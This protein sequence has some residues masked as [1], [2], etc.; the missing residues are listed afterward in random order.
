MNLNFF[1]GICFLII[2][3][4]C[5]QEQKIK[6]SIP[7]IPD[8]R[9]ELTI[10]NWYI[11]HETPEK[12]GLT[13]QNMF[14]NKKTTSFT[15]PEGI[16]TGEEIFIELQ[17]PVFVNYLK[18]HQLPLKNAVTIKKIELFVDNA[19]IGNYHLTDSVPLNRLINS[20]TIRISE[21]SH[22]KIIDNICDT[23]YDWYSLHFFDKKYFFAINE[24]DFYDKNGLKFHKKMP[25]SIELKNTGTTKSFFIPKQQLVYFQK[26]TPLS[27]TFKQ[28]VIINQISLAPANKTQSKIKKIRISINNQHFDVQLKK[29]SEMQNIKFKQDINTE[30]LSIQVLDMYENTNK[31]ATVFYQIKLSNNST[32][33]KIEYPRIENLPD[34]FNKIFLFECRQKT[35]TSYIFSKQLS[36]KNDRTFTIIENHRMEKKDKIIKYE[37]IWNFNKNKITLKYWDTEMFKLRESFFERKN[38]QLVSNIF[39]PFYLDL[40]PSAFVNIEQLSNDFILDMKYATTDNFTK[41]QLYPCQK[42]LLRYEVAQKLI[43]INKRFNKKGYQIKLFDCYRPFSV[44]QKMWE[45]LPNATYVAD[46]NKNGSIHNRGGAIDITLIDLA[47]GKELDMGTPFDFFGPAAFPTCTFLS[48]TILKNRQLLHGMMTQENFRV[49]RSEWWHYSH[50][51]AYHY[52]VSDFPLPCQ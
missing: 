43:Q 52:P 46:P 29:Q 39:N 28:A 14:D 37:G 8:F 51:K 16:Y 26:K 45:I 36:L 25:Q 17:F 24:I 33:F 9:P 27:L 13:S 15:T 32:T 11:D 49:S 50:P 38:E 22:D 5:S 7:K 12:R 40:S 2:F 4:A 35:D 41:Q 48:D 10:K 47:T 34:Y 31:Q 21:T 23:Q 44:Q 6:N 18:I 3:S 1:V 42:C 30:K 20:L 19:L